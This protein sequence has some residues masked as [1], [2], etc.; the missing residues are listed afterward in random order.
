VSSMQSSPS[1]P[2]GSV[3]NH[4]HGFGAGKKPP[5]LLLWAF[6][7]ALSPALVLGDQVDWVKGELEVERSLARRRYVPLAPEQIDSGCGLERG[8]RPGRPQERQ[9]L[10][11]GS[12]ETQGP[13]GRLRPRQAPARVQ[14]E[15]ADLRDQVQ[16]PPGPPPT[17]PRAVKRLEFC[18]DFEKGGRAGDAG[19]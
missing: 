1:I 15:T 11:R 9:C 10:R 4:R 17:Y 8:L 2:E 7:E 5:D 14:S 16:Q 18:I 12:R 6:P 3:D 13:P 19:G